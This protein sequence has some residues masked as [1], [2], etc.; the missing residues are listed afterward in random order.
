LSFRLD[1]EETIAA[2]IAAS[3]REQLDRALAELGDPKRDRHVA[4][5]EARKCCKRLRGLLRLAR[6]GLG[7]KVY[8]RENAALRDAAR[9]L[10]TLRDAEALLE[11]Y[12]RLGERFADEIDRRRIVPVRRVLAA[13]RTELS[14]GDLAAAVAAFSADL[15]AVRER[16]PSWP[17]VD[18]FAPLSSSLKRTYKRARKAMQATYD[19]PSSERFHDWRK[20]VK[21]HRYHLELL[22]GLWPRQIEARREEVK[23]L[24]GR[25]GDEHDLA[26]LE[27]TLRAADASF[28]ERSARALLNLAGQRRAELRAAMRPLGQRLFAERPGAFA[29]RFEVDWR[30]ARSETREWHAQ[31]RVT[32]GLP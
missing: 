32:R 17:E 26:V 1:P 24:G 15:R 25:L 30:V 7:D 23:A 27:A 6:S 16:V 14:E 21:Y 12:D 31:G 8:R 13:R 4:I 9:R 22:A 5:H 29:R 28:G 11:T 2:G 18:D 10:S 19:A 20:R 3:A